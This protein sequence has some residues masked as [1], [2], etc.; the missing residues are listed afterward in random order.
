MGGSMAHGGWGMMRSLR[1]DQDLK[2]HRVQRETLRRMVTFARPYRAQLLIFMVVVVLDALVVVVN[3]LIL[4]QIINLAQAYKDANTIVALAFLAVLLAFVDAGLTL[5]ERR[6][7]AAIGEYL[8]YDMRAKVFAHVQ[9]MPIAFF[10]RTQTGALIS[11]LNNDIIGA[12]QAFTDLLSNIV[13]NAVMVILVLVTMALLSWQVTLVALLLVPIFLIPAKTLSPRL[14]RLFRQGMGLNAEMNTMMQERFN[15]SGAMLVKLFGRPD[16]ERAAFDQRAAGVRDIGIKQATFQRMFFV[17]LS[18]T[19]ALATAFAF[20]YG[21]VEV[22]HHALSLGTV[23]ALTAYLSR[24][25]APLLQLSNAQTDLTSAVVSFERVF[26]VLDI[27]P[28]IKEA[29]DAAPIPAGP[30]TV[31]FRDVHFSY[32]SA[33]EVSIASLEAVETLERTGHVEV[34][35]GVT[36]T[37][38]PG[39]VVALV[40]PSGAGKTTISSLIPRLYD[41]TDGEVRINGRDL[42]HATTASVVETVGVVTQDA[43]LF[44]DSLRAN[45]LYARPEATE[46]QLESALAAAQI[47]ELVESLPNGLE[48]I[49]G[50]R[51]YRLSGGEKQRIAIARL[52]LKAPRVVVLDEATAHLDA[53]SEAAVQRALD[54]TLEGRTS[55]VIA[56]R[57]STIRNADVIL[58]VANGR[59]VD[60]GTH[61]ELLARGGLYRDLYETQFATQ[62]PATDPASTE[63]RA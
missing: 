30:A 59:I 57:L 39:S 27:E 2:N 8:I 40:G 60:R 6:I 41:P 4:R 56:H 50:E 7:A 23:V 20:G 15:V 51:G 17:G 3:P 31:E 18:L 53:E 62:S 26:E 48:T 1:R 49:V 19:A 43:H 61:A 28:M 55:I 37:V 25:F 63:A 38:A 5:T 10:S 24:L 9:A 16:E 33:E 11:R 58:V 52:L 45:L 14:G 34:L 35:R 54:A 46:R 36:F 12:Q 42:R 13:G 21:G 22:V 29:P 44:H 47:L 32:P